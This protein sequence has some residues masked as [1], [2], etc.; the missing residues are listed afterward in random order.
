MGCPFVESLGMGDNMVVDT[1]PVALIFLAN[2]GV[3]GPVVFLFTHTHIDHICNA[4]IISFKA[5]VK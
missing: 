4:P 3:K 1:I 2:L 5:R